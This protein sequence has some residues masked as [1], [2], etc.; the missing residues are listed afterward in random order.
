MALALGGHASHLPIGILWYLKAQRRDRASG[1]EAEQVRVDQPNATYISSQFIIGRSI[2]PHVSMLFPFSRGKKVSDPAG[3]TAA[4]CFR[5][6]LVCFSFR[7]PKSQLTHNY[8]VRHF[9]TQT[10]LKVA[11]K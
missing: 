5:E 1:L 11:H 2:F 7:Y 10:K 4:L 3:P 9:C 8:R 6:N